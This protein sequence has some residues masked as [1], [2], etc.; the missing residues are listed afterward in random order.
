ML[1]VPRNNDLYKVLSKF[2]ML[3]AILFLCFPDLWMKIKYICSMN[4]EDN[5]RYEKQISARLS[6][7]PTIVMTEHEAACRLTLEWGGLH[8]Q[9]AHP[10]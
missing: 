8:M 7:M 5:S 1:Q 2:L 6:G 10:A 9:A 4:K 3:Q